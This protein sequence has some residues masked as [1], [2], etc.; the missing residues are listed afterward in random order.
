MIVS[1]S[2]IVCR[3]ELSEIFRD[4]RTFSQTFLILAVS[5]PQIAL[6]LFIFG[7]HTS[8]D[9]WIIWCQLFA[10]IPLFLN[11]PICVSLTTGEKERKTIETTLTL[12]ASRNE[13]IFGKYLAMASTNFV[14]AAA[15][16]LS[17]VV[18]SVVTS[19][20]FPMQAPS[21]TDQLFQKLA[22][23]FC[24]Y[25]VIYTIWFPSI[26]LVIGLFARNTKEATGLANALFMVV[27]AVPAMV[28]ILK[29]KLSYFT[30][31]VPIVAYD[32]VCRQLLH[33]PVEWYYWLILFCTMIAYTW[34]PIKYAIRLIKS[35]VMLT[36]P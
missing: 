15:I 6:F 7:K 29:V 26:M 18:A 4:R 31:M 14:L 24:I 22:T 9:V 2:L 5:C 8:P 21:P 20:L 11:A 27:V 23:C 3:K 16:F 10:A 13:L 35:D 33:S 30:I 1:T 28:M 34:I 19:Y 36:P 25:S 12:C 17:A 32:L